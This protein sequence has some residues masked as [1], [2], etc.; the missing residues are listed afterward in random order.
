MLQ[1]R[2]QTIGKTIKKIDM[3]S[4]RSDLKISEDIKT[5]KTYKGTLMTVLC[6][7]GVAL[8]T[9]LQYDI[10]VNYEDTII[11]LKRHENYYTPDDS[12]ASDL[13]F[14]LAVGITAY[15][16][17]STFVEDPDIVTV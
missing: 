13:G 9:T 12:V 4:Y 3:F 10:M 7:V 16:G 6:V 5:L 11:N 2:C 14:N 1:R 8:F 15:D 17:L